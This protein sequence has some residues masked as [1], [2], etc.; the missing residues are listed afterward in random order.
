MKFIRLRKQTKRAVSESSRN[1]KDSQSLSPWGYLGRNKCWERRYSDQWSCSDQD[2][3]T[4]VMWRA[5]M[6]HCPLWCGFPGNTADFGLPRSPL[7]THHLYSWNQ[8]QWTQATLG[9]NF[10]F[11]LSPIPQ[12]GMRGHLF[13]SPQEKPPDP[14]V[15]YINKTALSSAWELAFSFCWLCSQR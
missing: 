12:S 1:L 15:S 13:I 6:S 2:S 9:R 7:V 3:R 10:S 5:L 11:G 8:P 14:F 4:Q